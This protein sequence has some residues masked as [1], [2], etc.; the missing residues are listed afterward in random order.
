MQQRETYYEVWLGDKLDFS[1]P[2]LKV[3]LD[4]A[5]NARSRDYIKVY[6]VT[7]LEEEVEY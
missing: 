4:S 5:K 3:C 6:K 1:S 2:S 7:L